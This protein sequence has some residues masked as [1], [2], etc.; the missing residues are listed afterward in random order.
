MNKRLM[1]QKEVFEHPKYQPPKNKAIYKQVGV[2]APSYG[3]LT[4]F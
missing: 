4:S 2:L 3:P 1:L